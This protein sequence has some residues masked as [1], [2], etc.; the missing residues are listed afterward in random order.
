M[1][2]SAH[3]AGPKTF[4]RTRTA[5]GHFDVPSDWHLSCVQLSLESSHGSGEGSNGHDDSRFLFVFN[6]NNN[7]KSLWMMAS[8]LG[9]VAG[10][11]RRAPLGAMSWVCSHHS[12][13]ASEGVS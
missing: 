9:P 4:G 1:Q 10:G 5:F 13:L 11:S 2:H 6:N 7:N 12:Q 8:R 3:H